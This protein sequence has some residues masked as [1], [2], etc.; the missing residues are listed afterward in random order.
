MTDNEKYQALMAKYKDIR[1]DPDKAEE[2]M[3]LLDAAMTL[4]DKGG[5]EDDIK[6]GMA[7]L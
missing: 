6:L 3:R 7:Y 2:S 4:A 5:V 1:R